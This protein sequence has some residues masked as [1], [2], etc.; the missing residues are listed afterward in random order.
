MQ[1]IAPN[2]ISNIL[3]QI[4]AESK[5][6]LILVSPYVNLKHWFSIENDLKMALERGVNIQFYVRQDADNFKSWEQLEA[7]GIKPKFVKNLHAKLYFNEHMGIVTSMNLLTSSHLSSIEIG[8]KYESSNELDELKH[9]VKTHVEPFVEKL[10]LTDEE[11]YL[12]KEKFRYILRDFLAQNL[13]QRVNCWRNEGGF[14]IRA[15]NHYGLYFDK[16]RNSVHAYAIISFV[17]SENVKLL[18]D[19]SVLRN[20]SFEVSENALYGL[21]NREFSTSNFDHLMVHEKN[22][23]LDFIIEF[24]SEIRAFKMEVFENSRPRKPELKK[25]FL[26]PNQRDQNNA[27][28]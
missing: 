21:L 1:T 20:V 14:E 19:K 28:P 27:T 9:F 12:S 26:F 15:A 18:I 25:L 16:A 5:E 7:I 3:S 2:Q 23:I 22:I 6:Y 11:L 4:I 13:R 24:I 10:K 17:E 8:I